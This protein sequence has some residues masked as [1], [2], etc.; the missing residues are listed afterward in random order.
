M[1]K[2]GRPKKL[3]S[4]KKTY[5]LQVGLTEKERRLLERVAAKAG[6]GTSTWARDLLLKAARRK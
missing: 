5:T 3:A 6:M 4:E 1:A 2:R